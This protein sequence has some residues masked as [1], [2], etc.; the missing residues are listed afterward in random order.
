M[1][2]GLNGEEIQILKER[3]EEEFSGYYE[4]AGGKNFRFFHLKFVHMAVNNL[5]EKDEISCLNY[6]KRVLE[7]AALF[8][9][10]GRSEDIEDGF[11]DPFKGHKSHA[12]RGAEL[13]SDYI[14]DILSEE[15]V[16]K[17]EKVIANH[18]SSPDTVEG[19]ILQDADELAKYGVSDI[20]RMVHYASEEDLD[21]EEGFENFKNTLRPR[22]EEGLNQF[23]FGVSR[24]IAE[25]RMERQVHAISNM[26]QEMDA[27]DF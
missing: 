5:V 11:M 3:L 4:K 17:V 24:D 9:D 6:D 21:I 23:N 8:H 1:N 19:K 22:L 12:E 13:V 16:G 18:H 20:W 14:S 2:E 27:E 15:R 26:E 10:I 7:A 25:K